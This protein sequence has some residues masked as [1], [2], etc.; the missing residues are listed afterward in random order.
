M[1]STTTTASNRVGWDAR[2]NDT[3]KVTFGNGITHRA[4]VEDTYPNGCTFVSLE[5]DETYSAT[6]QQLWDAGAI[7]LAQST[8]VLPPDF[9]L[10]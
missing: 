4:R 8:P 9:R 3:I 10:F 2:P 5:D 1:T 7:Y 6:Y